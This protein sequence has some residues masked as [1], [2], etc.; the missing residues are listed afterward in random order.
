MLE[1]VSNDQIYLV[2]VNCCELE[3]SANALAEVR[4]RYGGLDDAAPGDTQECNATSIKSF[5]PPA[6]SNQPSLT[7]R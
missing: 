6:E 3:V 7:F 1:I 2:K 4:M 5:R